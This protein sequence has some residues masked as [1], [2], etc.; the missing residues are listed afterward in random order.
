ML[1]LSVFNSE[2]LI[3]PPAKHLWQLPTLQ[4]LKRQGFLRAV[5]LCLNAID[6]MTYGKSLTVPAIA[7]L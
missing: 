4:Y 2:Y 1:C 5:S 6:V 7:L 3:Y